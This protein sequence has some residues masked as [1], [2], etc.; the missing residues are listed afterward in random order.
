MVWS[1][2]F[3]VASPIKSIQRGTIVIAAT[4][5]SN[6]ATITSVDLAKSHLSFGG[7]SHSDSANANARQMARAELTNATTV[8]ATRSGTLSSTTIAYTVVEYV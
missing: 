6:T 5:A 3:R 7:S 4:N 1:D 8:T 2:Q